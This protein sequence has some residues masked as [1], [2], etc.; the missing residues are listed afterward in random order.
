MNDQELINR[1]AIAQEDGIG[2]VTLR[3]L[4]AL[5]GSATALL[6]P[7]PDLYM[8]ATETQRNWLQKIKAIP[9]DRFQWAEKMVDELRRTEF[10]TLT[11]E[12]ASYPLRLRH[13][14]D[15]PPWIFVKG[16]LQPTKN[17]VAIVGS[18]RATRYGKR[19]VQ[20]LVRHLA[21]YDVAIVSGLAVGIDVE[22]H[23]AA[24]DH[25]LPTWAVLAHGF[26]LF[27]PFTNRNVAREMLENG[28]WVTEF[29]PRTRPDR[30]NFPKR[31]RIIA[32]LCDVCVV[33][34]AARTGGALIT[35][36]LANS[37]GRDVM[38]LPGRVTD[39]ISMGCNSL[40]RTH[41]AHLIEHP[42]NLTEL[43][44]WKP[45]HDQPQLEFAMEL[46]PL[47]QR[48]IELI[49]REESI[50]IETL[51]EKLNASIPELLPELLGLEMNGLVHNTGAHHYVRDG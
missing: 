30:E 15:A 2:P 7:G 37:Y 19:F 13:C 26:D 5:S 47:Q 25:G 38:A 50:S 27:Y 39:E 33:V 34:E 45:I 41:Q 20:H 29:L 24:I 8:R 40:I 4:I 16:A 42:N 22:A 35:A 23:R 48:L 44:G 14:H 46:S 49:G 43:L 18:R 12:D 32:G 31:N 17:V 6:D 1:I 21:A 51:S 10:Q 36:K 3:K 9:N 28:A 11:Y